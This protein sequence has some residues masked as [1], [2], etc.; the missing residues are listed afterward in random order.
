M[1]WNLS[2]VSPCKRK[3]NKLGSFQYHILITVYEAAFTF[4]ET[5]KTSDRKMATTEKE[6][7]ISKIID[8]CFFFLK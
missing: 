2:L 3:P 6:L 5:F 1:T 7:K 8:K 4:S